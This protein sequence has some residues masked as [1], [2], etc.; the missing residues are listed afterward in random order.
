VQVDLAG[1]LR[2]AHQALGSD[3]GGICTSTDG[4]WGGNGGVAHSSP[5]EAR[6]FR[7]P[8]CNHGGVPG[9]YDGNLKLLGKAE[10]HCH[11]STRAAGRAPGTFASIKN[12]WSQSSFLETVHVLPN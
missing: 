10:Q 6:C 1:S 7:I 8:S 11:R 3:A 12:T 4:G 2:R 9:P 5:A